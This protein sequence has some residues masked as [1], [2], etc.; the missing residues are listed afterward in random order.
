MNIEKGQVWKN[1]ATGKTV[2]IIETPATVWRPVQLLHE[3]GRKTIKQQHYFVADY[4][5]EDDSLDKQN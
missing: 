3:S 4:I 1:I 2:T 5:L